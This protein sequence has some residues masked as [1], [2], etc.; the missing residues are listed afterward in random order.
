[1]FGFLERKQRRKA[2]GGGEGSDEEVLH[3]DDGEIGSD[4][5]YDET[6]DY[7]NDGAEEMFHR[8]FGARA[9]Q[10]ALD[11]EEWYEWVL[12]EYAVI[13]PLS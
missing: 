12:L 4:D 2:K 5:D 9:Q 11:M 1:V 13:D 3:G 10:G 8:M 6:D 7:D